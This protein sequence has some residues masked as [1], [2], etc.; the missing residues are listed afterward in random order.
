MFLKQGDTY[1]EPG[2][3][4]APDMQSAMIAEGK[5]APTV[6]F[7]YSEPRVAFADYVSEISSFNV[8]YSVSA[9]WLGDIKLE[10]KVVVQDVDECSYTGNIAAFRHT[11]TSAETCVNTN[12]SFKCD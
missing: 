3:F 11:C 10:R 5:A 4:I 7:E 8:E 6:S 2:I 1:M 12:G 9:S